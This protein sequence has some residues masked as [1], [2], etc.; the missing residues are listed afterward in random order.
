MKKTITLL[1]VILAGVWCFAQPPVKDT[2]YNCRNG[3][4]ILLIESSPNLYRFA[5]EKEDSLGQYF[6]DFGDGT[7]AYDIS[8][9]H[10]YVVSGDYVVNFYYTSP[11]GQCTSWVSDTLPATGSSKCNAFWVAYP[12]IAV[13]NSIIPDSTFYGSYLFEDLSKGL[14][15]SRKWDFGDS[16]YSEEQ[17]PVH[18]YTKA[19][20]YTACLVI[21]TADSCS[22]TYCSE[23]WVDFPGF[24]SLTGTVKDYTGLDGCGFVIELDN[25]VV[26]EPVEI[27]PN[28]ILYDGERVKLSYTELNDR[29]SICM[30]GVIARIDCITEIPPDSC[31]ASF[32]FYSLPWVSSVPPIYQFDMLNIPENVEVSWDFG[33]GTVTNDIAPMHRFAHD[34]YYNVCLTLKTP[35]CYTGSCQTAWFDGYDPEPGLCEGLIRLS[36]DIILNG[37]QCNGSAIATLVDSYG[38]E[39]QA[40]GYYWSTGEEGQVIYNLCPGVSYNVVVTDTTGCAVSGSFSFGGS[41]TYPDSLIG[42]WNYQQDNL[43]FLFNLPVYSDSVYCEWDFG[44]GEK[45][46]GASVTHTFDEATYYMVNL[47]VYDNN[48]NVVYDQDILVSAGQA[49]GTDHHNAGTP[50]VYPV[51]AQDRLFIT[52]QGLDLKAEKIEILSSGGQ[53][54][55]YN[56]ISQENNTIEINVSDLRP[57]F[58]LGRILYQKGNSQTFRFTK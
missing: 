42:Y 53:T 17:N 40:A 39:M 16:T 20:V 30:A 29:E 25:G 3:F 44:D 52:I 11:D 27:L 13:I 7:Y 26:L 37:Q 2:I 57:G 32:T 38:N 12:T 6:W 41:V 18:V 51:P 31:S 55:L 22:S 46:E 54:I 43:D 48:G 8:P 50:V 33:D 56:S 4:K 24:C 36:T 19:G 28:F 58:Y 34:G 5:P 47:K 49:L 23:I 14:V 10:T 21:T 9:L 45:A 1:T 15:V 35:E